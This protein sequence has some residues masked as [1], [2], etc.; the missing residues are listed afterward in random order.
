[1]E[2]DEMLSLIDST[3]IELQTALAGIPSD[4]FETVEIIGDWSIKELMGHITFWETVLAR[5]LEGMEPDPELASLSLDELNHLRHQSD[6]K[7]P[8]QEIQ[9]EFS[10][11]HDALVQLIQGQ[12]V[13]EA[14]VLKNDTWEHYQDHTETV[15]AWRAEAG[16]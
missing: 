11:S 15:R 14:E 8:L 6:A 13:L 10:E 16:I 5:Q 2:R 7:R 1:M 3:W 12:D 4:R 9:T